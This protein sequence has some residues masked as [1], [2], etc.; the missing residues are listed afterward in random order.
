VVLKAA[1]LVLSALGCASA[2]Q[3]LNLA[4]LQAV[5][6]AIQ[7]VPDGPEYLVTGPVAN[8]IERCA[9]EDITTRGVSDRRIVI[10]RLFEWP[11]EKGSGLVAVL[12]YKF[13]G[14]SPAGSCWSIGL[15]VHLVK[16]GAGWTVRD[17]YLLET[18]H[19]SSIPSAR[20]LDLAGSGIDNLIVESDTGWAGGGATTLS[21]FDLR[22]GAFDERLRVYSSL[23]DQDQEGYSQTLD[24]R[25]TQ[26]S[27][28]TQFCFVKALR[29][30]NGVMFPKSK[31]SGPCY[32]QG[33]DERTSK[34]LRSVTRC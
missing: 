31:V 1:I 6:P 7:V 16:S 8:A 13:D 11:N 29:F 33:V 15:L 20:M 4:V 22:R 24:L 25:R 5:F 2:D 18:R 26:Q 14:A 30:E 10:L 32:K 27:H 34:K 28:G 9:A 12:Q 21:I 3:S 17:R 19:H 23:A